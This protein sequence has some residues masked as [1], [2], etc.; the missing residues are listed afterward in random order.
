[1]EVYPLVMTNIPGSSKKTAINQKLQHP[2]KAPGPP[3]S[4]LLTIA[5]Q[6]PEQE[7]LFFLKAPRSTAVTQH[8]NWGQGVSNSPRQTSSCEFPCNARARTHVHT[9]PRCS[10]NSQGNQCWPA[11]ALMTVGFWASRAW[12]TGNVWRCL[13]F[14]TTFAGSNF[15]EVTSACRSCRSTTCHLPAF[16]R[17]HPIALW[18][19]LWW[20][21]ICMQKLLEVQHDIC[22]G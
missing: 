8:W 6:W 12:S 22:P 16:T 2:P 19:A 21:H 15:D 18:A 17:G 5:S 1:M 13:Y 7:W 10:G 9:R 3:V 14:P 4:M 11:A 20:G